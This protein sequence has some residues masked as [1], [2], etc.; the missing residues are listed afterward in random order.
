M[1]GVPYKRCRRKPKRPLSISKRWDFTDEGDRGKRDRRPELL[2]PYNIRI[3]GCYPVSSGWRRSQTWFLR[4]RGVSDTSHL[5]S[6]NGDHIW[7]LRWTLTSMAYPCIS[8][9]E[10]PT[11]NCAA[12]CWKITSRATHRA[13]LT[14]ASGV[15]SPAIVKFE[16][17]KYFLQCHPAI[18][19][20]R[21]NSC[22]LSWCVANA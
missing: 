9:F 2:T 13:A 17:P 19:V 22:S 15:A 18:L 14:I 8:Q 20:A 4:V 5:C 10:F 21:N 6:N 11:N 7:H 12:C 1:R 16:G 3:T